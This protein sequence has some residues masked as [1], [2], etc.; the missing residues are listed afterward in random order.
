M[1]AFAI[2]LPFKTTFIV[3]HKSRDMYIYMYI[4]MSIYTYMH[5]CVLTFEKL[6]GTKL[7]Y[8]YKSLSKIFWCK[9]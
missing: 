1:E 2:D 3:F 7:K 4:Y 9:F 5:I 8:G 6:I